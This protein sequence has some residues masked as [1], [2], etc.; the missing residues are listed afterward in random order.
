MQRY[1]GAGCGHADGGARGRDRAITVAADKAY[2]TKENPDLPSES[3]PALIAVAPVIQR[4]GGML[5]GGE[6]GLGPG[7]FYLSTLSFPAPNFRIMTMFTAGTPADQP[8]IPLP[9]GQ[10]PRCGHF[11]SRTASLNP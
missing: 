8:Q 2:D 3:R 5:T 11:G 10:H 7:L 4:R 6:L 1:C 9:K